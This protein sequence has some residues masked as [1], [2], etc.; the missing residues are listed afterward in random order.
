M[1]EQPVDY[2][3]PRKKRV[4]Q[5]LSMASNRTGSRVSSAVDNSKTC[6]STDRTKV[7]CK[8]VQSMDNSVPQT[9]C[10]SQRGIP[11]SNLEH[12]ST[13][14]P[15]IVDLCLIRLSISTKARRSS[16]SLWKQQ[17]LM[18]NFFQTILLSVF[19]IGRN[20]SGKYLG[21]AYP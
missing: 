18:S 15:W 7:H 6:R 4:D 12:T 13:S 5:G 14:T 1:L 8:A 3:S 11:S 21:C 20:H 17:A 2:I 10:T 19:V 16:Q 9:L